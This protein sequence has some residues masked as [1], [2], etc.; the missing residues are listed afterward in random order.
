M[1]LKRNPN[2]KL[3]FSVMEGSFWITVFFTEG[4]F[5]SFL[6]DFG[7][8][9]AFIGLSTMSAGIAAMILNPVCGYL[10]DKYRNCRLMMLLLSGTTAFLTPFFFAFGRSKPFV[11]AYSLVAMSAEKACMG[12]LDSWISKLSREMP[13]AFD[14]GRLR[15]IGSISYAIAAAVFGRLLAALG[16]SAAWPILLIIWSIIAVCAFIAPNPTRTEQ[17]KKVR[18][19]FAAAE[20]FKNRAYTVFLM[21]GFL[22]SITNSSNTT[23]FPL[24]IR[25]LGGDVGDVG[26][27]YFIL[28][29][30][31]F[32]VILSF[33]RISGKIG[34]AYAL[35]IGM[36]GYGLK[37]IAF[38]LCPSLPLAFVCCSFQMISFALAVPGAVAYINENISRT[39]VA[40]A[41]VMYQT[42]CPSLAQITSSPLYGSV[43][44]RY[45]IRT[46]MA[47]FAA[48]ALVG[49]AVF[50]I[51]SAARRRSRPVGAAVN[52][53]PKVLAASD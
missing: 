23:F 33:S 48:P 38:A 41:L 5:S 10:V 18:I 4:L 9:D 6:S 49:G 24:I 7:Y 14:Y 45:G 22:S 50:L 21:C 53:D 19:R 47:A 26:L 30:L 29:F 43:S 28:A 37:N 40:S 36:V 11:I 20:L 15:S 46:M 34:A 1:A 32:F 27:A 44:E 31:E 51:F 3:V 35:G 39:Y 16:N 8:G 52:D 12:M 25:S 2:L 13:G 17:D 42:L